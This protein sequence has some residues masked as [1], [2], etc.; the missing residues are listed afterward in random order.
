M[1]KEVSVVIPIC[2]PNSMLVELVR[3]LLRQ[4]VL[5]KELI[6]INT[7]KYL[8][9]SD[10]ILD[11]I[12]ELV[13]GMLP[14]E[15]RDIDPLEFDHG[16]TRAMGMLLARS[17]FVLLMTQDALPKNRYLI[18]NLLKHFE[19]DEIALAY[20][21]Q[22]PV[23]G[24]NIVEQY[25]RG[26][27]YPDEDMIKSKE[28]LDVLGI[29]TYFCSDVCAMY[30]KALY[31]KVGGFPTKTIFNEDGIFAARAI[32]MGFKIAY[33]SDAVVIHSHNYTIL[34]QFSRNFDLG[35]SHKEFADVFGKVKSEDEGIKLV[36]K[37][38]RYLLDSGH[39]Y[40]IPSLILHSG[41]KF[42]GYRLGKQYR[43]LPDELVVRLSMNKNYWKRGN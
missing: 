13:E 7:K 1:E 40:L 28:D 30:S 22:S 27:N 38:V 31:D 6:L 26:F 24:C 3:R 4:T 35:V 29:K 11:E 32:D 2:M 39:W 19:N 17:G 42:L 21:K 34:Q 12:R 15:V 33:A 5:P 20:A 36:T 16:A 14:L 23:K 25:T 41:A 10:L 43:L 18:A 8:D 37:T 9:G